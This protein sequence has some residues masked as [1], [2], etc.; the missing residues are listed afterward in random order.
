MVKFLNW[1]ITKLIYNEPDSN[2]KVIS[3]ISI[4]VHIENNDIIITKS[5]NFYFSLL[6]I[7]FM[8]IVH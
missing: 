7:L 2:I 4:Y 5:N 6:I 8:L 3:N 1:L